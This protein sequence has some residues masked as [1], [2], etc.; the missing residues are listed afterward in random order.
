MFDILLKIY[1][2]FSRDSG[3]DSGGGRK[4]VIFYPF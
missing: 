3:N 2:I 4:K 1:C